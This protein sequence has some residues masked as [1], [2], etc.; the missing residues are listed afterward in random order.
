[1]PRTLGLGGGGVGGK[2]PPSV[3]KL[4]SVIHEL[5]LFSPFHLV[6]EELT[7]VDNDFSFGKFC[8]LIPSKL[9]EKRQRE[10]K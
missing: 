6:L 9:L 8:G 10:A 7:L 5:L 3:S 2:K 4:Q 1:M